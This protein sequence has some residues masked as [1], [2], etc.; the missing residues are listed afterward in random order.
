MV[1]GYCYGEYMK[2]C[3]MMRL[4]GRRLARETACLELAMYTITCP[5]HDVILHIFYPHDWCI[6]LVCTCMVL[7]A[8]PHDVIYT[9]GD[10]DMTFVS[11]N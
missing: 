6:Y 4:Y 5:A 3:G 7:D 9:C 8:S 10:V 1:H 11:G 2:S